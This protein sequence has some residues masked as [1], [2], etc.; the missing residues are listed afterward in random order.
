MQKGQTKIVDNLDGYL[1]AT[2][3]GITLASLGLGWIG[4]PAIASLLRPVFSYFNVS[5]TLTH[6]ISIA[7]AFIIITFMHIVL[8]ELAP[9]SFAIQK[10][11]ATALWVSAPL[12]L[13]NRMMYPFIWILNHASTFFLRMFGITSDMNPV[14]AHTEEE[15]R[16]LMKQ[17]HKSG[18]IDQTELTL[19]DNVFEFA[20]RNAREI[21]IPRTDMVCM[22]AE[23]TFD[24]N[25]AIA[26]KELLPVILWLWVIKIIL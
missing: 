18:L 16:I 21:M 4:E 24:E 3:L 12:I 5:E 11:E 13:F 22:F 8:G 2:Q 7:L 25:Y 20:E 19:V 23:S 14:F 10:A 1:S 26:M 9:K 6:T 17:S 15:I